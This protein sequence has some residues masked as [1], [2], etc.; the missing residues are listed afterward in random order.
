MWT[1][2]KDPNSLNSDTLTL[3][4]TLRHVQLWVGELTNITAI[5]DWLSALLLVF[6]GADFSLMVCLQRKSEPYTQQ[7]ICGVYIRV[8]ITLSLIIITL[9]V[10]VNTERHPL[11]ICFPFHFL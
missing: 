2:R 7:S 10:R 5:G 8:G 3:I 6:F 11:L 9:R 1:V 4:P